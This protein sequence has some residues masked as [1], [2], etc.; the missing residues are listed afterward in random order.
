MMSRLG[1]ENAE[2][3]CAEGFALG[4][5]SP[6]GALIGSNGMRQGPDGRLYIAQ[7]FGNQIS[8]V[9]L[10][11]SDV[12]VISPADGAIIAPDDLGFDSHGNLFASEVMS[13]R[14]SVIRPNGAIEVIAS[15]TPVANGVT[16]HDD[17]IFLSEFN[18]EGRIL[19]LYA[20]GRT[21]RVIAKNLM[22]P[23]ALCLGPDNCLYFP[24]V[25]LGEIW[26][27]PVEGG[28]A[29]RVAGDFTI[30]T[31]VKFAPDGKLMIV[32]ANDG[33]ITALDIKNGA[34][35]IA[36]RSAYGIDNL[37]YDSDGQ[38]YVSHFTDGEI[39]AIGADGSSKPIV[40]GGMVGPFGMGA[41]ADGGVIIADGMSLSI[42]D[43][44]GVKTR[45]SMLLQHGFPG[46]VRSVAIAPDGAMLCANS[47]GG[48]MRYRFG[49][50]ANALA[51]GLDRAMGLAC[52]DD[53]EALLCESGAGKVLGISAQGEVRTIADNL[54]EPT[55][56]CLGGNGKIFV[57]DS[58]RGEVVGIE[59]GNSSR[60]L[61]GL[62]EPQGLACAGENLYIL[63]KGTRRLH[64]YNLD[65]GAHDIIAEQ[66]PVGPQP[67]RTLNTLPGIDGLM[68]GPLSNFADL[69]ILADG[70][71]C[72]GCD[73]DGSVR[74]LS[75][76]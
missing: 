54:S 41:L 27:V 45:P 43:A 48:L 20:D 66:L 13:A 60:L 17:R 1:Q 18:P 19:E 59:N 71:I 21:P 31:A 30:P 65:S 44:S 33:T 47:A 75:A 15:D 28:T 2:P 10:A 63:D 22:M 58:G 69:A 39:S 12:S 25:P 24:L 34:R 52:S 29:E 62:S 16:V 7:A 26:R 40:S 57:S 49:E 42:I 37:A 61:S 67:G 74:T 3:T 35:S 23:N 4:L 50:E 51:E 72:I 11:T 38:L 32:D 8:A 14:V 73:G 6:P 55:G 5:L 9:N 68:P 64:R 53:G 70:R 76:A 56:I 36:G 46:Y